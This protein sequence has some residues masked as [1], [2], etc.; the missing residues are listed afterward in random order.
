MNGLIFKFQLDFM[1]QRKMFNG[2]VIMNEVV[3][4]SKGFNKKCFIF[5]VDFEIA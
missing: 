1:D 5:K 3:D 4:Y 2:I